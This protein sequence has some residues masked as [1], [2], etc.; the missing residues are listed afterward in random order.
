MCEVI[1][2]E[3]VVEQYSNGKMRCIGKAVPNVAHLFLN[4]TDL[5]N[6]WDL[7]NYG[8][9]QPTRF[10]PRA[11]IYRDCECYMHRG[12]ATMAY[13]S[14]GVTSAVNDD[15]FIRRHYDTENGFFIKANRRE[16]R[17]EWVYGTREEF[18]HAVSHRF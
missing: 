1:N 6:I 16:N 10:I 14:M 3:W 13:V 4:N 7:A 8:V 12:D 15:I 5:E 18:L 2:R 17:D 9:S 11:D